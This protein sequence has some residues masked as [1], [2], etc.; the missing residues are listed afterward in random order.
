[1]TLKLRTRSRAPARRV[2]A[3]I[4]PAKSTKRSG[5]IGAVRRPNCHYPEPMTQACSMS[6]G[7]QRFRRGGGKGSDK[8]GRPERRPVWR[9]RD[10]SADGPVILYGWHT[11]AAALANPQRHIRKLWVTENAVRR[12]AEEHIDPG[13]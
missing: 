12:L 8:A 11:V 3:G 6:E 13:V 5:K 10:A 2:Y 9:D 7:K 4:D 1:M